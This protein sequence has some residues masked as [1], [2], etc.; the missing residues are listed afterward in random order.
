MKKSNIEIAEINIFYKSFLQTKNYFEEI[1][2]AISNFKNTIQAKEQIDNYNKILEISSKIIEDSN[3][4][5]D[6]IYDRLKANDCCP[7]CYELFDDIH[8]NNQED[9]VLRK[10]QPPASQLPGQALQGSAEESTENLN[11]NLVYISSSCCNNKICG[12]CV[13]NWYSKICEKDQNDLNNA[14]Q[15]NA[16]NINNINN[17]NSNKYKTSCIFCNTENITKDKMHSYKIND[18][19]YYY[20]LLI[21]T[22]ILLS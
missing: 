18:S 3:K 11:S 7:I 2:L 4:K 17:N 9:G 20:T 13:Y 5:I 14:N 6:L 22:L 19:L 16:E 8:N 15:E 21:L 1:N 12:I 10:L